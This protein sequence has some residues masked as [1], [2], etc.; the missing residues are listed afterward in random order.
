MQSETILSN[1]SNQAVQRTASKAAI[2]LLSVCHLL[3]GCEFRFHGLAVAD[4]VSR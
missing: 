4:L 3:V 2:Y 1:A